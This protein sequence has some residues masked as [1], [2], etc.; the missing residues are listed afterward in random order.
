LTQA[1]MSALISGDMRM[2]L[3][4]AD[5]A[6]ELALREGSPDS[7][8]LAHSLQV[9]ARQLRG[10]LAGAEKHFAAEMEL[11]GDPCV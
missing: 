6:L 4:L 2:T 1:G 10:D 3:T 8:L 5:R 11:A 9:Q 7:L